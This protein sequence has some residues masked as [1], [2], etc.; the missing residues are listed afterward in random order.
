MAIPSCTGFWAVTLGCVSLE[1][2][3][4]ARPSVPFREVF[5]WILTDFASMCVLHSNTWLCP[6][7]SQS[8]ASGR[9]GSW[10]CL[11]RW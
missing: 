9:T 4:Q 3:L 10:M 6:V 1:F 11:W 2:P 7:L 8:S 5:V